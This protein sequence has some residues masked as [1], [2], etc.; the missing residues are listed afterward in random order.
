MTV[1][2]MHCV[3]KMIKIT[4]KK[5]KIYNSTTNTAI[6]T[7]VIAIKF[8][9]FLYSKIF[10]FLFFVVLIYT[11]LL[12]VRI[13]NHTSFSFNYNAILFSSNIWNV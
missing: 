8:L 9:R 12:I 11:L 2:K 10:D 7:N 3:I 5:L 13:E 4:T 1:M 6:K